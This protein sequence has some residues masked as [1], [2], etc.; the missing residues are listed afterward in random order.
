VPKAKADHVQTIRIEFNETERRLMRDLTTVYGIEKTAEAIN[1]LLSFKNLYIGITVI[2]MITGKE[3]L[4]GT[5]NDLDDLVE[6]V[7]AW[8][9]SGGGI[10][11]DPNVPPLDMSD[12]ESRGRRGASF[13]QYIAIY[14]SLAS[15]AWLLRWP[16]PEDYVWPDQPNGSANGEG[17]SSNGYDTVG[18][19][20]V[21]VSGGGGGGPF[22]SPL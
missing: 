20:D 22:G 6:G 3:I 2:E 14:G 18:A 16:I 1:D 7:K 19:D 12:S 10:A 17:D 4:L 15:I 8:V 11:F 21:P 13:G 5:P 9:A